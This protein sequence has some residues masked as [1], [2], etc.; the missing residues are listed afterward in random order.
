MKKILLFAALA[1]F[2]AACGN[3][4]KENATQDETAE[5]YSLETFFAKVDSLVG[6]EIQIKGTVDHVCAHSGQRFTLSCKHTD[7]TIKVVVS[8]TTEIF[9]D[10]INGKRVVVTGVVMENQ[11]D[12]NYINEWEAA[13]LADQAKQ[14]SIFAAENANK[15]EAKEEEFKEYDAEAEKTE[16]HAEAEPQAVHRDCSSSI[17]QIEEMRQYM[18][19]NNKTYYPVYYIAKKSIEIMA[20]GEHKGEGHEGHNH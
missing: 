12:T 6:Q 14:D 2:F 5:I 7:K 16:E 3:G 1:V 17:A 15:E 18:K 8:D 20:E 13:L 10:T 19:D 11:L 4:S 9:P